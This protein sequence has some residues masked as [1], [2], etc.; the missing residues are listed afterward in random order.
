MSD[1]KNKNP[2]DPYA[3]YSGMAVQMILIIAGGSY[4]GYR[5]DKWLNLSF[6]AFTVFLSL[7]SVSLAIYLL[8]KEFNTNNKD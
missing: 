5:L 8:I 1:S 6:P 3:R 4:G 2:I 7:G